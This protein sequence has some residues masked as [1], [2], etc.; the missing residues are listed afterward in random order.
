M[1]VTIRGWCFALLAGVL[2][3]A[4]AAAAEVFPSPAERPQ[5][6]DTMLFP[7]Q[8]HPRAAAGSGPAGGEGGTGART[9]SLPLGTRVPLWQ[10]LDARRAWRTGGARPWQGRTGVSSDLEDAARAGRLRRRS[11]SALRT[12]VKGP[13]NVSFWWRNASE[14]GDKL[15]F[16]V[17]SSVFATLAGAGPWEQ[18]TFR[19]G[20]GRHVL[21]WQ[22]VREARGPVSLDTAFLDQVQITAAPDFDR[23]EGCHGNPPHAGCDGV[24]G[25]ADDA[26]NVMGDGTDPVGTGSAPK[27]FDDGTYGFS[28][29]GHGANG[30]AARG[31]TPALAPNVACTACHDVWSPAPSTHFDC[32]P[33]A[34]AEERVNTR[35]FFGKAFDTRT[36]NT[37]HLVPGFLAGADNPAAKQTAFDARCYTACHYAAGVLDMRHS[38]HVGGQPVRIMEFSNARDTTEDPKQDRGADNVWTPWTI[39]D[40]T[41]RVD[42][43]PPAVRHHGVCVSCHDPHGTPTLQR[44]RLTNKMVL[45]DWKGE[46]TRFFCQSNCHVIP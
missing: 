28:V 24:P 33:G 30:T 38:R 39:D 22:F 44:S 37:A 40:L 41:I 19:V 43:S 45:R 4:P 35:S 11:R 42:A 20:K 13:A 23:C 29:N 46:D 26:P 1:A 34:S 32:D 18:R 31:P 10:A 25:T 36:A 12:V 8:P 9:L 15:Q 2:S 16:L 6:W 27:P 17:D 7:E 21:K 5:A 3:F 14:L